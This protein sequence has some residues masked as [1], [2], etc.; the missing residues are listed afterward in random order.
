MWT[1]DGGDPDSDRLRK[2]HEFDV[3]GENDFVYPADE[4]ADSGI[5]VTVWDV[6]CCAPLDADMIA[7]EYDLSREDLDAFGAESQQRAAVAR[8]EGRFEQEIV[9]I[10]VEIG[11]REGLIVAELEEQPLL[12]R[13]RRA[14]LIVR[15][16]RLRCLRGRYLPTPG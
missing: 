11:D 2:L 5:D 13:L 12:L 7:D 14:V 4:L 16:L 15:L 1:V 8:D 9:P 10:E 3:V 6:R